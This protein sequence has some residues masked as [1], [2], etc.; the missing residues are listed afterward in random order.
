ARLDG[1]GADA[2]LVA[3]AR[4]CLAARADDRPADARQVAADVAAYRAGVE[5]RL[6]RAETERAEALVREAEQRKRRRVVQRA[7]GLVA[8]VLVLGIVGTTLG[9]L[10]AN[11][12][13]EN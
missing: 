2:D 11:A 7:G 5:A 8:A 9:L 4:R 12:A 1:C 13:A 3:L 6:R 10:R